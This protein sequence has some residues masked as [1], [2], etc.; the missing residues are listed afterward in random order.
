MLKHLT[1]NIASLL[2]DQRP[3]EPELLSGLLPP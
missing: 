3:S 2:T 1:L